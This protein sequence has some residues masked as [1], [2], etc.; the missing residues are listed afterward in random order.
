MNSP[1]IH[2]RPGIHSRPA[3]V[4]GLRLGH[5]GVEPTDF[6][7][8]SRPSV[9]FEGVNPP[10]VVPHDRDTPM[11]R[12]IHDPVSAGSTI[13]RAGDEPRPQTVARELGGSSPALAAAIFTTS[14]TA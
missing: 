3:L 13:G 6:L 14:T 7:Q 12:V 9:I 10:N 2:S 8:Q 5:F 4:Q 1:S 11:A